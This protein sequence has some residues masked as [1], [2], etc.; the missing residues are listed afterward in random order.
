MRHKHEEGR[1]LLVSKI[2]NLNKT[3]NQY[4]D[5]SSD[6]NQE[7][8]EEMFRK[9]MQMKTLN[10]QL[11]KQQE[12]VEFHA[13]FFFIALYFWFQVHFFCSFLFSLS[14]FMAFWHELLFHVVVIF[15]VS[16]W[17]YR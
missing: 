17:N 4:F 8:L 6:M 14:S 3:A 12:A 16:V 15:C 13:I 2:Q 11:R 10:Y 7:L 1:E 5:Q 9:T